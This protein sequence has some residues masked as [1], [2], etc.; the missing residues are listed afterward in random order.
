M[1]VAVDSE[2]VDQLDARI[3]E[4]TGHALRKTAYRIRQQMGPAARAATTDSAG[5]ETGRNEHG[6]D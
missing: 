4:A 1:Q 3:A 6:D 5:E 2:G